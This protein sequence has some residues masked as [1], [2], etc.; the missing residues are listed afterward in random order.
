MNGRFDNIREMMVDTIEQKV[1]NWY[2]AV[3]SYIEELGINWS[4]LSNMTKMEIK[5]LVRD[6]D[7]QVWKD[8]LESKST[9]KYYKEGKPKMGYDFCYRNSADS[10]FLARAR[11]NSLKLE[12]AVGRGMSFII[13]LASYATR[14]RRI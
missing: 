9:L 13:G 4:D 6:Y 1:G 8:N 10:M 5:K 12:E 2:E 11:V 3:D 7:T 14:K